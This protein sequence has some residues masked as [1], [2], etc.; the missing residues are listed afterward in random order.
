MCSGQISCLCKNL[1]P[2]LLHDYGVEI[3]CIYP[4]ED[5]APV[6]YE[7]PKWYA[8]QVLA[9]MVVLGVNK[10]LLCY[11]SSLSMVVIEVEFDQ[12]VWAKIWNRVKSYLDKD[13]PQIIQ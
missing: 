4:T 13:R 6:C 1:W 2:V 12:E 10:L 11:Y 5:K 8:M 3:K 7:C 9:E